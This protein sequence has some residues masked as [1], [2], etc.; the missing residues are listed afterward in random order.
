MPANILG[1]IPIPLK[2][3]E[4]DV[5]NDVEA[6]DDG[7]EVLGDLLCSSLLTLARDGGLGDGDDLDPRG[8]GADL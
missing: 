3:A 5:A 8:D 7:S 6:D 2:S 4:V 1:S